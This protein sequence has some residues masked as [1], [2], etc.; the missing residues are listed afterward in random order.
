MNKIIMPP[1]KD[2]H[3]LI[4]LDVF[5]H[6]HFGAY[7]V[8][9]SAIEFVEYHPSGDVCL[10]MA[11]GGHIELIGDDAKEFLAACNVI[12]SEILRQMQ[13]PQIVGVPPGAQLRPH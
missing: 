11:S 10:T 9:I 8:K 6:L 7:S 12:A 4:D 3:P 5:G 2:T 13:Q 1:T